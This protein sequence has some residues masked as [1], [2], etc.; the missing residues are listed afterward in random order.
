[1]K[2]LHRLL[3]AE[4]TVNVSS[5]TLQMQLYGD[6]LHPSPQTFSLQ[7]HSS[8]VSAVTGFPNI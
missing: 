6:P 8:K 1:M 4:K 3:S 2:V 7:Q 5:K